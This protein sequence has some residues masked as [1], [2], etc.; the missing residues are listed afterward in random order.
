M[1]VEKKTWIVTKLKYSNFD[2]TQKHKLRQNS[3]TETMTKLKNS[4]CDKTR[5]N[6]NCDQ[7]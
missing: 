2:K 3:K 1:T 7:T 5:K 6:L 4:I